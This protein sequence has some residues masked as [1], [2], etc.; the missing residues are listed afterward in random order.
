MNR[1]QACITIVEA[2]TKNLDKKQYKTA[3]QAASLDFKDHFAL[4]DAQSL[5]HAEQKITTEEAMLLYETL[6]HTAE[7]FN[8][9]PL[10]K[11]VAVIAFFAQIGKQNENLVHL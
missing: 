9:Q 7:Q 10:A 11:R 1:V 3:N 6:G 8:K 4:Q 2:N 5:L